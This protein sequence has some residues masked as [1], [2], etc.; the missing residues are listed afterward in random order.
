[1]SHLPAS[2]G[3]PW[4]FH[5]IAD[6][7]R[8]LV[9]LF[10][11]RRTFAVLSAVSILMLAPGMRGRL[12]GTGEGIDR[13]DL[14]LESGLLEQAPPARLV[15]LQAGSRFEGEKP[16]QGWSHLVIKSIPK[17]AT[18][19][20]DTL[21]EQA[22]ETA[23]RVRPVIVADVRR[24]SAADDA[25]F[26]LNR[27]SVGLCA[28]G[29]DPNTEKVVTPTSIEGTKGPWTAKQRL[30]L[31]AMSLETSG[32]RLAAATSTF[33]L[34]RTPVTFLIDGSHQKAEVCYA[35]LVDPQRGRLQTLVWVDH[36]GSDGQGA[37]PIV[38]RRIAS[39]VFDS[40]MDVKAGRILGNIPVT[41]SFAVREIPPGADIPFSPE[42]TRL[43]SSTTNDP[44]RSSEI[45]R[46]LSADLQ[47][48]ETGADL[49]RGPE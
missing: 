30:I 23:R 4:S 17:L 42:I 1:M 41:W 19:D 49:A 20:L 6:A 25:P 24:S 21:S 5:V 28:P 11:R 8:R 15:L 2:G 46:A 33:A 43:L 16:P 48:R 29:V 31:A 14:P 12:F 47:S 35:L 27:V 36:P 34:L 10:Q 45:G 38:A 18:G 3:S 44:T 40:P 13:T 9:A 39:P 26:R 32:A 37:A 7:V 22:F